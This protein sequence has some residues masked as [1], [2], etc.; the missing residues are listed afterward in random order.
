MFC[1]MNYFQPNNGQSEEKKTNFIQAI[2][3][4]IGNDVR[5]LNY[6]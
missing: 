6:Y 1:P 4:L 2:Q 3:E 5:L